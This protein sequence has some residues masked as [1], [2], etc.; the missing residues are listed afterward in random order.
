M[1]AQRLSMRKLREILHL[2]S[3]GLSRRAIGRSLNVSHNT[4]GTYLDRAALAGVGWPKCAALD[5]AALEAQVF[6]PDSTAAPRPM[7]DWAAYQRELHRKGVRDS[8][9]GC[10]MGA[11]RARGAQDS[12]RLL[13]AGC[14]HHHGAGSREE[15]GKQEDR[16]RH[17]AYSSK[18]AGA[19]RARSRSGFGVQGGRRR[20]Y[21]RLGYTACRQAERFP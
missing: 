9:P 21:I 3:L 17:A 6:P 20:L 1:A 2:S 16:R 10:C 19:L 14:A 8:K 12:P 4:A 11:G 13:G 15:A 18:C 7:P 5:D